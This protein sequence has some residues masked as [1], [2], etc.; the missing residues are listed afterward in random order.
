MTLSTT[1]PTGWA[2]VAPLFGPHQDTL[3][4]STAAFGAAH[5]PLRMFS[6]TS[7]SLRTWT[8]T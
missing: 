7:A 6:T 8:L 1:E 3:P 4:S 2:G 5:V